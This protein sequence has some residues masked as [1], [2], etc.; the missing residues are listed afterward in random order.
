MS[1]RLL[2]ASVRQLINDGAVV[3]RVESR[4]SET[5]VGCS[6]LVGGPVGDHKGINVPDLQVPLPAL[7]DKDTDDAVFALERD[8]DYFALSFVQRA[9]DV[10][11]LRLLLQSH[12]QP[13]RVLPRIIAKI[14]KPQA[15]DALDS[16]IAV[17]DGLMVAR[18]D[19]GVEASY[20]KVPGYQ[21]MMIRKCNAAGKPVIVATQM[22]ESM[23]ENA[24]P[25][26]AEVSDIYNSVLDGADAT[27]L[28]AESAAGKHP[29]EAVQA[30]ATIVREA[31]RQQQGE[32]AASTALDLAIGSSAV[33]AAT[34]GLQAKALILITVSYE[35]AL[36]VSKLRP[37]CPVIVITFTAKLAALIDLC[38]GCHCIV[39]E[40]LGERAQHT[41]AVLEEI[42]AAVSA[43]GWLHAGELFV[44]ACGDSPLPG[45]RNS[46]QLGEFGLLA[47]KG[48]QRRQW[49]H[50]VDDKHREE[51]QQQTSILQQQQQQ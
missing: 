44:L 48:A 6:V 43:R 36:H 24:Q 35:L 32:Q 5:E 23:I 2:P 4:V 31:E 49:S 14:E 28:S 13:G 22:I 3:L 51:L 42:E 29:V 47:A 33:A 15:I 50:L 7:T 39:L 8:V 34:Q 12:L 38:Y 10:I 37:R 26:R 45:L 1:A 27:M 46:L 40:R 41:D 16:I 11:D 17:V 20:E 19:L 30:M 18:G 25:T 21:K 9:Q